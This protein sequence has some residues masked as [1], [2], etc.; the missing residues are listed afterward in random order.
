MDVETGKTH[1]RVFLSA[2][3][4][5]VLLVLLIPSAAM[6]VKEA[7]PLHYNANKTEWDRNADVVELTG[8][9]TVNQQGETIIADFIRLHKKERSLEAKGNVFYSANDIT[10]QSDEMVLDLTTRTGSV[11]NGRMSSEGFSLTGDRINKLSATRY[12]TQNGSYTT[13]KDCPESWMISGDEVDLTFGGYVFIKN[14][15]AR[16]VDTPIFWSPYLILPLKTKRQ[17][18]LLFPK[19]GVW[20][21]SFFVEQP[22]FWALT[23]WAD[24]TI[25]LGEYVNRGPRVRWEGRYS[26][27]PRSS[28]TSHFFYFLDPFL[29][30]R[31]NRMAFD[32]VGQQ[33]L[34][35][36]LDAK[37]ALY[38][39]TDHF[40]PNYL[41]DIPGA[42]QPVVASS[43]SISG[44]SSYLSG[45]VEADRYRNLLSFENP[46]AFD[47]ST[48]QVFPKA[49]ITTKDRY[50]FGLPIATG[51]G[52][53][54]TRFTRAQG[55]FDL[56]PDLTLSKLNPAPLF[57][58]PGVA[59]RSPVPGTDPIRKATRFHLNP[60]VYTSFRPW[61]LIAVVPSLEY[62]GYF[63][64]F[65]GAAPNLVRGYFVY[66][67]D[68]STQFERVYETGNP[69]APRIK[70]LIR[71][72]LT[73]SFIPYFHET[74][75]A[76]GHPFL[77]QIDYARRFGV[78]G[79]NFDNHDIVPIDSNN[80]NYNN[81]LLP[82]GNAMSYGVTTQLIRRNGPLTSLSPNYARFAEMYIRQTINFRELFKTSDQK[83]F[84]NVDLGASLAVDRFSLSTSVGYI[85]HI[86]ITQE[87]TPWTFSGALSYL[88]ESGMR[89]RIMAFRRSF[90]LSYRFRKLVGSNENLLSLGST[91]SI[92]DSIMPSGGAA[93]DFVLKAVQSISTGVVFQSPSQCWR[94]GVNLV[95]SRCGAGGTG[96]CTNPTF[97]FTFNFT[98]SG[99]SGIGE[100]AESVTS[101]GS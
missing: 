46:L 43:I 69:D 54:V 31:P 96:Y 25:T 3:R 8:K 65:E 68:F 35:W 33:E 53:G 45:Y 39:M 77:N 28:G 40:N 17:S 4:V 70:H 37:V 81:N 64:E 72:S 92:T 47:H 61:D 76:G 32:F 20:N 27:T 42:G 34:P 88:L 38:E 12:Q 59:S 48:V 60:N 71:P 89:Q 56:G 97:D 73:Y 75:L 1:L 82:I 10:I 78:S 11:V 57:N 93:F 87:Q 94:F 2:A 44:A 90:D 9:A 55:A 19:W 85:P 16:I 52:F 74:R 23:D 18:G 6:A 80:Q 30:Q 7:E 50:L 36:G 99:F 62:R 79:Y 84:S 95:H 98:G 101:R 83:P 67:T 66:R 22:F 49:E 51:V 21:N 41:R 24:M 86:P 91:F 15:S 58:L 29:P 14:A 63:Y 100:F 26:L 5:G 13:C